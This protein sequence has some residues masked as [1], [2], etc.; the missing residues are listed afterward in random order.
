[1]R[2]TRAFLGVFLVFVT[3]IAVG[4]Q[5]PR[6][7]NGLLEKSAVFLWEATPPTP[8]DKGAVRRVFRAP[9]VT[10]D[11]L[12]YHITTLNPSQ[13]PHAPHQH[14]NEE[15]IIVKE[16]TV[17]AYVNGAWTPVSTG[18]LIFFASNVPHTVRNA[19]SVPATYHV[20]NWK[21]PGAGQHSAGAR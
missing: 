9:S 12:E 10:L 6:S 4:S 1:M 5:A 14:V 15:V 13:S 3:G 18:S 19:G 7:G 16:G 2:A 11:E 17:D 20:V 21:A 8:T